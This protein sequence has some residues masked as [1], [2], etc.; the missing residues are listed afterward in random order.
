MS[1]LKTS[2]KT[3]R[4]RKDVAVVIVNWNTL[5]ML[6][7]C[8]NSVI[9][10]TQEYTYEIIVVD[11]NSPD[12]SADMVRKEFPDVILIANTTNNGFAPANNQALRIANAR[13]Y[14]LLNPD[15]VVLNGAID[16][17]V[18]YI[19]ANPD[20]GIVTCK[21]LNTDGTLQKSVNNFFSFSRSFIENRF[22]ANLFT[23]LDP[24]GNRFM[25]Y[26]DHSEDRDI[27]WAFGAVLLFS[28][29]VYDK[30]GILDDRFF[31][32][33][34]EMD[35]YFRVK[36]AGYRSVFLAD[37]EITH[38][39][40]SSSRQRRAEMFIQNYKSFYLYL[41]KHYPGYVYYLY[42]TRAF[43]YMHIWVV[44]FSLKY[45]FSRLIMKPDE[46]AK[47]QISV[48]T[49]TIKWHYTKDSKIPVE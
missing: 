30:V 38:H 5:A 39:G 13:H 18:K 15:T 40:K 45:G 33:A 44:F 21:L 22:L 37:V 26:W 4:D 23:R 42:R 2:D 49:G 7:D 10:E 11:N 31:I 41:R 34:E 8:L 1:E 48:Y 46:E 20:V 14:L 35:F 27:D 36:K 17:M 29:E 9:Q 19:D 3:G 16:K 43:I 32:Y 24:K 28:Q 47:T 6:R 12:K 25:S